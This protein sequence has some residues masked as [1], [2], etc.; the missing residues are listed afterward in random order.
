MTP[1]DLESKLKAEASQLIDNINGLIGDG[2]SDAAGDLAYRYIENTEVNNENIIKH[3]LVSVGEG[4][5]EGYLKLNPKEKAIDITQVNGIFNEYS[6]YLKNKFKNL[7]AEGGKRIEEAKTI[8]SNR[9]L[10]L[11]ENLLYVAAEALG[12]CDFI[13]VKE[14]FAQASE[15]ANTEI[16]KLITKTQNKCAEHGSTANHTEAEVFATKYLQLHQL[17]DYANCR[18]GAK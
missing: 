3:I 17:H 9:K 7:S 1:T 11:A 8:Y 2:E 14:K 4:L 10:E 16:C 13:S 12:K 18:E 6:K 5:L 15:L